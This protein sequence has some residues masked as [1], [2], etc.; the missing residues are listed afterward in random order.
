[1]CCPHFKNIL[2]SCSILRKGYTDRTIVSATR[3]KQDVA[4][5]IDKLQNKESSP[6][7]PTGEESK[8]I[9]ITNNNESRKVVIIQREG[10]NWMEAFQQRCDLVMDIAFSERDIE[11]RFPLLGN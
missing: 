9:W 6:I 4:M 3:C 5:E 2:N 10:Q 1:M 8:W 7:S 11:L